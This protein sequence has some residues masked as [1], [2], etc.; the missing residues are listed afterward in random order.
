[1]MY[2]IRILSYCGDNNRTRLFRKSSLYSLS[3]R[4][5]KVDV[6]ETGTH[7]DLS[8]VAKKSSLRREDH[9]YISGPTI[10]Q[11]PNHASGYGVYCPRSFH[12][13]RFTQDDW[14]LEHA[15]NTGKTRLVQFATAWVPLEVRR[16]RNSIS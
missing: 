1:M 5:K 2:F 15:C 7:S 6:M 4:V 13:S 10:H 14:R 9:I 11:A 16:E 3:K 12:S 8:I